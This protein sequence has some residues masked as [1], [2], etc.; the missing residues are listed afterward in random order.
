VFDPPQLGDHLRERVSPDP[1]PYE[2]EQPLA[3]DRDRRRARERWPSLHDA[4]VRHVLALLDAAVSP[5]RPQ[6]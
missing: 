1:E 6:G 2:D 3:A 4:I 5:R